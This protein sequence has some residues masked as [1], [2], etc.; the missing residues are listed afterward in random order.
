MALGRE[1]TYFVME[2]SDSNSKYAEDDIINML[3][4]LVDNIFVV[5]KQIVG[6]PIGTNCAHLLS[7]KFLYSYEAESTQ[8]L[9]SAGNKHLAS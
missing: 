5:F 9:L 3:E 8:S 7:D 6:I 4:F 2:H 1:E